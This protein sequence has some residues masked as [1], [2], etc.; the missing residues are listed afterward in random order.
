MRSLVIFLP[1]LLVMT[2]GIAVAEVAISDNFDGDMSNWTGATIGDWSTI[3]DPITGLPDKAAHKTQ[4][5]VSGYDYIS[6][7]LT[8]FVATEWEFKHDV[9]VQGAWTPHNHNQ[10]RIFIVNSDN[11]DAGYRLDV[12]AGGFIKLMRV[13]PGV[14]NVELASTA[15][16]TTAMYEN[17]NDWNTLT[18]KRDAAGLITVSGWADDGETPFWSI[19]TSK[20][21]NTYLT[22]DRIDLGIAYETS[23]V[24][25]MF[26][27][28]IGLS[29][30]PGFIPEPIAFSDDFDGDMSKW[31]GDTIGDW[32]TIEDPNTGLPDKAAHKTQTVV[33]GYDY[34]S[35]SFTSFTA[36]EWKLK[37][38]MWIT[39]AWTP[40]NH[41][42]WRIFIVDSSNGDAGYRL[43][44]GADGFIKLMRV[45]PGVE[46]VELASTVTGTTTAYQAGWN[47][48]IM[49]RD[50]A[51]LI[52]VSG[53]ADDGETPFWSTSTSKPDNTYLTFDRLD[54]GIAYDT[55]AGVDMLLDNMEISYVAEPVCGDWGYA[56]MDFNQDCFVDLLDFARFV[57]Y[58]MLCSEPT[59]ENCTTF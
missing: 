24:S 36:Q 44:V 13:K 12:G 37:H 45:K 4:T 11:G 31:T 17:I 14:E 9:M 20:P 6:A 57:E 35:A 43:D 33:S 28:N 2:T 25:D 55:S 56:D 53:W 10:W 49:K 46:N 38:D 7:S 50:A 21:D 32:S 18:W 58:W 27:D 29:Y 23:G 41:N 15:T 54:F 52:T 1:L 3:A 8:P 34:I 30:V 26:F 47:I 51:G 42:Q 22:F 48:L 16:G 40:H 59:D 5:V 19:S 39:G